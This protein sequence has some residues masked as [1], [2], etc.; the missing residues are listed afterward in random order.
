MLQVSSNHFSGSVPVGIG[1]HTNLTALDLKHN[2]LSGTI[3]EEH[4]V[5]LTNLKYIDLSHNQLD[6]VMDKDWVPP[7]SLDIA[8]FASCHLGPTSRKQTFRPPH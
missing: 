2:S 5:G 3:S 6:V 4:F 8:R 1:A 7:F